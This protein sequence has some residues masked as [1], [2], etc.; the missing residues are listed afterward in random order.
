MNR[1]QIGLQL[2][3]VRE[4]TAQDMLDTLRV[5]AGQGYRAVE[6]AGLGGVPA[7]TIRETLD[8]HQ[9]RA[10][11]AHVPLD[12]WTS[13]PERALA[14]LQTLGCEFAVV[15]FVAAEQRRDSNQIQALAANLN[16]W[17]QLCRAQ[18]LRLAYHNHAF[19]FEPL[20]DVGTTMFDLLTAETDPGLVSF[21]LDVYWVQYA[22]RDPIALIE[23]LQDRVPLLH[24]KDML[25]DETRADAPI[26]EGVM[27]W[28]AI[29]AAGEAAGVQWYIIEQDHPRDALN[30]VHRSLH[31]LTR[32]V[33]QQAS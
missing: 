2:Y 3:T 5:L 23:G 30:D 18:G 15:P 20:A 19:E 28:P 32:L 10:L 31:N 17:G 14:E 25:G 1:S 12:L 27:P 4:F 26:G 24:F 11:G 8:Q 22:G 29:L 13:Q 7:E 16:R 21:E 9:M 33:E 6:F